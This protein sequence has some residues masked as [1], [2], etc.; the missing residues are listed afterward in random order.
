MMERRGKGLA[1]LVTAELSS[2]SR[3]FLSLPFFGI[4]DWSV[5]LRLFVFHISF[6]EKNA[7]TQTT[8]SLHT[9]SSKGQAKGQV[10]GKVVLRTRNRENKARMSKRTRSD[11]F[12]RTDIDKFDEDKY[13]DE[14]ETDQF[15]K[16]Q[17]EQV[18]REAISLL[19]SGKKTEAL[20]AALASPPLSYRTESTDPVKVCQHV[21]WVLLFCVCV[22]AE[23]ACLD[24]LF[25]CLCVCVSLC[26]RLMS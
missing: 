12:R 25:V 22:C 10:K 16:A 7:Q 8:T 4:A 6:T 5:T 18:H 23:R 20:K 1:W 19:N 3:C 24:C 14:A 21:L 13:H 15:D 11:G 9:P 2:S 17:A 26:C